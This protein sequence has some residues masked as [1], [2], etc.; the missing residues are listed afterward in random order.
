VLEWPE[1]V[2]RETHLL[3][4]IED[5]MVTMLLRNPV[6]AQILVILAICV[7]VGGCNRNQTRSQFSVEF[8]NVPPA[9][10]GGPVPLGHAAGRV[11]GARAGE[12]IVF[13]AKDVNGIWWVQPLAIQ[14]FTPIKSDWSWE[15]DTHLGTEYAALLVDPEYRPPATTRVLPTQ[16]GKVLAVTVVRGIGP[17]TQPASK[18]VQFSGYEWKAVN[19]VSDRNGVPNAYDPTNV[20]IDSKGFLHLQIIRKDNH[21]TCSEV[22]L[23][24]SFGYG[25]YVFSLED[26]SGLPPAAVLTLF[27]WDD[28][29]AEQNH[30]EMDVEISRWGDPGSKNAQFV[31]QPYYV[32]ENVSRFAAPTGRLTYLFDWE[33]DRVSFRAVRGDEQTPQRIAVAS[34]I[35]TSG[36]PSP[37]DES[38]S[39]NFCAFG[40]SKVPLNNNAEVVIDRF[41]Y[42]P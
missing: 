35:F 31:M 3:K 28:L 32:P 12:K 14:P 9:G 17:L 33:P 29:G 24:H 15:T 22:I 23:P 7:F 41:Q 34:H 20:L 30:R 10:Q 38:V 40:F 5:C 2:K 18:K 16:G 36:I 11:K 1:Q 6:G 8:N 21:W 27:T 4:P 19:A 37:G 42:L 25:T 26:V 39:M 13:Y